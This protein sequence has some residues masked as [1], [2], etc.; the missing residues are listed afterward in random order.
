MRRK[1]IRRASVCALFLCVYPI[2]VLGFT[3]G[4]VLKSDFKGGRH[5]QLDAYRHALA[6]ATVSYTLGEWAVDFT[7]WIFESSDKNSNKMDTHNNRIGATIGSEAES[8]QAIELK[9]RQAVEGGKVSAVN[10]DQITWLAP[11]KWRDEKLW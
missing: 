11:S 10:L 1:I 3:W 2:F 6:S 4:H 9:V 5:G 8:L 7:T